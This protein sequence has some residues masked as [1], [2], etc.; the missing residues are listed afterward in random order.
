MAEYTKSIDPST[1]NKVDRQKLL[2]K[3]ETFACF[4]R[5]K[6]AFPEWRETPLA[7]RIQ[8]LQRLSK[9]LVEINEA[10]SLLISTESGKPR[11]ECFY[12]E[13]IPAIEAT[14]FY[15]KAVKSLF[16]PST[17]S[18]GFWENLGRFSS[19]TQTPKGVVAL[20]SHWSSPFSLP[21]SL[22]LPALLSGCTVLYKP[23]ERTP[24]IGNRICE[25]FHTL[26]VPKDA[27]IL[28]SGTEEVG[29]YL[30]GLPV[31]Q[32]LFLGHP[33]SAHEVLKEASPLLT[34]VTA[35]T[36]GNDAM[37]VLEDADIDM[38]TSGALWGAFHHMGQSFG[39]VKRCYVVK[40]IAEK[41]R[42]KCKGKIYR[43]QQGVPHQWGTDLGAM[44]SE[45]HL[46]RLDQ[47]IKKTIQEGAELVLGGNKFDIRGYGYFYKPTLLYNVPPESALLH[48]IVY[49]PILNIVLVENEEEAIRRTNDSDFALT[50]SIWT[51][52]LSRGRKIAQQLEYGTVMINEVAYAPNLA[53]ARL[54]ALKSSGIGA[55]HG[56]EVF[57]EF[58]YTK[59]LH[60]NRNRE[61]KALWWFPYDQRTYAFGQSLAGYLGI[62]SLRKKISYLWKMLPSLFHEEKR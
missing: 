31:D 54:S 19:Y 28:I 30:A 22:I 9:Y 20:F 38:A 50:A 56:K 2:S 39:S 43:L 52:N 26:G 42:N 16:K 29:R 49:G 3:E 48:E 62:P 40:S 24:V 21:I 8:I 12:T 36:G 55:I 61:H 14:N 23:S 35:I 1:F 11:V 41:F 45:K 17:A 47:M 58:T 60:E 27:L 32:I 25:L 18:L 37:I 57:Q 46:K 15:C 33:D 59:H 6:L 13:I 7:T 44:I 4:K 10:L 34:P 53:S 5:A 51:G